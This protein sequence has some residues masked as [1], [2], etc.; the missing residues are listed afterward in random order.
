MTKIL[1]GTSFAD[2]PFCY[3]D[4]SWTTMEARERIEEIKKAI[5]YQGHIHGEK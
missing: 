5:R 2:L 4:E 3:V 1:S